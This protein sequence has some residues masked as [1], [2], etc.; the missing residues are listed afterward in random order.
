MSTQ[1]N[2][3]ILS[4]GSIRSICS[5]GTIQYCDDNNLIDA[6]DTFI[7]TSAGA[8]IAYLLILGYTPI[9]LISIICSNK[10]F[11]DQLPIFDLSSLVSGEG[12]VSFLP[13]QDLLE[14]LTIEKTGM[15]LTFR[16]LF[17][18]YKKKLVISTLN[19][20]HRKIEYLSHENHPDLPCI[21]AI[22]M[23]TALPL[24]FPMVSYMGSKY[25][26]AGMIENFPSGY[27]TPKFSNPKC[28]GIMIEPYFHPN[29]SENIYNYIHNLMSIPSKIISSHQFR[30]LFEGMDIIN[31]NIDTHFLNFYLNSR[32]KL[33]LFSNGYQCAQSFFTP[34][35]SSEGE[36]LPPLRLDE[37]EVVHLLSEKVDEED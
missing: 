30:R 19:Y 4:G 28:L 9:D 14:K 6:V 11:K 36:D 1:Y 21:M 31:I 15:L 8:I 3:L 12:A 23:S 25:L 37:E 27:L 20:T 16:Q 22:R 32:E 34:A 35:S 33:D 13:I 29:E 10:L 24:I 18:M 2:T 7:A 5:L 17:E 26:D